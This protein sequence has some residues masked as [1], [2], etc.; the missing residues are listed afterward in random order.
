MTIPKEEKSLILI[1][2]DIKSD[3]Y[4]SQIDPIRALALK[5]EMDEANE[6]KVK[7]Y[8]FT[9]SGTFGKQRLPEFLKMYSGFVHLDFDYLDP[10]SVESIFNKITAIPFTFMCFLSPR[11][12]GFKVFIEVDTKA[13][14]HPVAWVQVCSY[15]ENALGLKSD[16]SCKDINRLCFVSHD[17]NLYKNLNNEK[18]QVTLAENQLN[19]QQLVAP[20][21]NDIPEIALDLTTLFHQQI[22]FTNKKLQYSVG[23]RNN[24]VYRLASN[25]NRVGIPLENTAEL[26]FLYFDLPEKDIRA[27]VQSAYTHHTHEF[28]KF[29]NSAKVPAAILTHGKG[30]LATISK[31]IMPVDA[32]GNLVGLFKAQP[33]NEWIEEAS[34]RPIPQML[35]S[36][37]WHEGEICILFA[38]SNLGK[39]LLAV[40]ISNSISKGIAIVGFKLETQKQVV[41]YFDFE[42]SDKQFENRYSEGYTYH[43]HFD[44]NLIRVE[45]NPEAELPEKIPFED[46][47]T[48]SIERLIIEK[49]VKILIIDNLTYLRTET[50]KAKDALP[51]MKLL[52]ALKTKY[53]LSLLIL[54]HT[55]KRDLF[56]PLSKNDLQGSSMLMN[57][58]DSSFAI[59]ESNTDSKLRYLKQIKA[60]NTEIMYD[61]E[62]VCVCQITKSNSFLQFEFI[63][64]GSEARHLKQMTEEQKSTADKVIL[65]MASKGKSLREIGKELNISHTTVKRKLEKHGKTIPEN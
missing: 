55:P 2:N 60:R 4:K 42:L 59:G 26:S 24:Y 29:A 47:L 14:K 28:G 36:E 30:S 62:N 35:F 32:S 40:Q 22:E 15:Y 44:D 21:L 3:K 18:F 58:C 1:G 56:K 9:P 19:E 7:L 50:E 5:G 52:K 57:F 16:P 64:F 6:L 27:S 23:D 45:I 43:Y 20:K 11:G 17:L 31:H 37:F 13:D 38:S 61:S 54:A 65:D 39:S 12:M 33:A 46:Y 51:L 34:R 41:L 48:L 49:G 25:C 63:G 10:S 53:G 8:S